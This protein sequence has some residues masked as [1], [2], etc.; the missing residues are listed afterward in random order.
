[1]H[2]LGSLT[3]EDVGARVRAHPPSATIMADE[4]LDLPLEVE[5]SGI[6]L[7]GR[8]SVAEPKK[9]GTMEL[10]QEVARALRN[11]DIVIVKKHGG[12]AIGASPEE[13]TNRIFSLEEHA[14]RNFLER[15]YL[16]LGHSGGKRRRNY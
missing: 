4:I 14:R 15:L 2:L 13:A 10:A 8:V 3:K 6:F 12:F 1:V 11:S 7:K 9:S 5:G 16:T